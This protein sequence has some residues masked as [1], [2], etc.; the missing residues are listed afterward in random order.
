MAR[1]ERGQFMPGTSGNPDGRPRKVEPDMFEDT[2][3]DIF[4][5]IDNE[6]IPVNVG[7][8][9]VK[10][11]I[12]KA[13]DRQMAIKAASGDIRAIIEWNKRRDRYI[14]KYAQD[15]TATIEQLV[16]SLKIVKEHPEDVTDDYLN[17]LKVILES[18]HPR[19][20]YLFDGTRLLH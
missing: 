12:R 15:T 10:M 18:L 4:F 14:K 16:A 6:D 3:R 13:I 7:G 20:Q 19:I 9:P 11:T 5:E 8:R 2:D 17:A 1:N